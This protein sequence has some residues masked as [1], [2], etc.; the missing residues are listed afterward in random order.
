MVDGK[1]ETQDRDG[2]T[3][4]KGDLWARVDNDD[5]RRGGYDSNS[6][7]N[8]YWGDPSQTPQER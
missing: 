5:G 1:Q 4:F 8:R 6:D 7:E 3:S 2:K